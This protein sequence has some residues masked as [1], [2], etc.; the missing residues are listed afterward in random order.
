M[1]EIAGSRSLRH[2]ALPLIALA[3][4]AL[5]LGVVPAAA[6]SASDAEAASSPFPVAIEHKFGV[7]VVPGG[8]EASR[9]HRIPR[10]R[11]FLAV[12]VVPVALRYNYGIIRTASSRG[13]KSCWVTPS[14][15]CCTYP[16]V[17]WTLRRSPPG[18]LI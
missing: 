9:L 8:A 4:M 17:N 5:L 13:D 16:P 11:V 2:I 1:Q 18:V 7:P 12:G 3:A 15:S 6:Q 14:P 10:P